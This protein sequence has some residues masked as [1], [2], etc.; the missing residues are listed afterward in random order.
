MKLRTA[1]ILMSLISW[2]GCKAQ[3]TS[4]DFFPLPQIPESLELLQERTDYMVEHYWDF[5]D[6]KKAFSSRDKMAEAFDVY[7]SFMPHASAEVVY[8]SVDAFMN[9]IAKQP[10]DVLFIGEQAEK[11]LYDKDAPMQSDDL[12]L[13]FI[14][15]IIDNKKVDKNAKLRYQH[16]AQVLNGSREGMIA[17]KFN[18]ADLLGNKGTFEIDTMKTGTLLFFNDPDCDDCRMARI[19]L[20][21]DI[22]TTTLVDKDIIDVVSVYA[23]EP[24]EQWQ[25]QAIQN[26]KSWTT[27]AAPDVDL[28]YDLRYSPQFYLL[29]PNGAILLKTPNIETVIAIMSRLKE[30]AH[31]QKKI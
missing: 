14:R 22:A 26:P 9:R 8:K 18:Y 23:G 7:V 27:V 17:P 16:Q 25:T 19:R 30:A 31:N 5:C 29:N 1:Y 10:A 28:A 13:A 11:L 6:L 12:Y 24:D 2:L 21:A 4:G 3:S 20:D 15:P